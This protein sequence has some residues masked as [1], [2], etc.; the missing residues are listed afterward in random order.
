MP[1]RE[2]IHA[3]P[4]VSALLQYAFDMGLTIREDSPTS[5]PFPRFV[6][7]AQSKNI[8][9]GVF[10]LSRPEWEYGHLQILPINSGIYAGKFFVSPSINYASITVYFGGERSEG[11]FRRLGD[12]CLSFKR[13][14]LEETTNK[15]KPAPP[16]V[17]TCFKKIAKHL[18]SGVII[19]A[20]VHRY[21]LCRRALADPEVERCLPP[22]DFIPWTSWRK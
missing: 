10:V 7:P 5:E 18:F 16:E 17:E 1:H 9:R 13:T 20:G 4:D 8:D 21:N 22:F 14:W 19:K 2:L 12:G 15:N 3:A 11:R 6:K